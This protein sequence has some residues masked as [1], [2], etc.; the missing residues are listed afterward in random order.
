MHAFILGGSKNIG[1]FA[2]LR[3]LNQGATATF[4]LRSPSVFDNDEQMQPFIKD[5]KAHLV[6]GDALNQDDVRNAWQ[7]ATEAGGGKVDVVLFTVG[8]KPSF[9]ITCG[10]QLNPPDLCTRSLFNLLSTI[11]D[12]LRAPET[13]PR[14]VVITSNGITSES[15]AAIPLAL[16]P[17]YGVL[18]VAPHAD[19]LGAERLL[20]HCGGFRWSSK[21][22]PSTK[23][24]PE[25]WQSTPGL[26]GTGVLKHLVIIRPALLTDGECR[27]D[28]DEKSGKAPY[29]TKRDGDLKDSYRVS[30]KDVAHFV[31]R[32]VLSNWSQWEGSGVVIGY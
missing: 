12:S 28:E 11:P 18:L 14:F 15:H 7:A 27:G 4:L 31:V 25:G 19:K 26:P 23:I 9:S 21:D 32:E 16:K 24:L 1:Y 22:V 29:R 13:Q 5:G 6:R 3:L 20:A 8:G 30:R 10:F 17:L 2:A